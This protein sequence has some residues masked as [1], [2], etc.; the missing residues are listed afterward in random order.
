MRPGIGVA[1]RTCRK[2]AS[3]AGVASSNWNRLI[4]R[5]PFRQAG[6]E[7]QTLAPVNVEVRAQVQAEIDAEHQQRPGVGAPV[8]QA[9]PDRSPTVELPPRIQAQFLQ[10]PRFE[11]L[12]P[13]YH[14][15]DAT[16]RVEPPAR[17][18]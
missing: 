8:P 3:S 6:P 15:A 11:L 10:L 13:K 7:A 17:F 12:W 18:E 16:I 14:V 2:S 5:L 4:D 9:L 1:A